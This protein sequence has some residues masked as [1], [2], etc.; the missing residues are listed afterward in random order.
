MN[1]SEVK[2]EIEEFLREARE[3]IG[4]G[5]VIFVPRNE[6]RLWIK[7][8]EMTIEQ[9]YEVIER[10]TFNNYCAGPE[11]DW[12]RRATFLWKFGCTIDKHETYIKLK[13]EESSDGKFV[14]C[15]SFHKAHFAL[16]YPLRPRLHEG[17]R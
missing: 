2:A 15:L 17:R 6:N 16:A 14:K 1:K 3:L 8:L 7:E 13:I 11:E 9:V 5:L 10:L 4:Q 12:D